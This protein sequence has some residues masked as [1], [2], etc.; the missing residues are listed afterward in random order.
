MQDAVEGVVTVVGAG[1]RQLYSL[2]HKGE[3]ADHCEKQQQLVETAAATIKD[4]AKDDQ[5]KAALN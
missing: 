5:P 3:R 2:I 4:P 1:V